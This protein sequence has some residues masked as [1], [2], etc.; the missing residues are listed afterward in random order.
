MAELHSSAISIVLASD[1][2]LAMPMTVAAFS[3]VTNTRSGPIN[4][5]ILDGGIMP[6]S[7][8]KVCRTLVLPHVH[9]HWIR[10]ASARIDEICRKGPNPRYSKAAYFRLLLPEI[11]PSE[12]KKVIYLD[13]DVVVLKD[14]SEL[15]SVEMDG[16]PF[17]AVQEPDGPYMIDCFRTF[18][19]E[20][21]NLDFDKFGIRPEHKYCNSGVMVIDVEKWRREAVM[22]KAFAFLE[23][24]FPRFVDQDALNVVLAG[25]W[26]LLDPKW[27]VTQAFYVA[28]PKCPYG[29]EVIRNVVSDPYIL[30]FTGSPKPW[31]NGAAP[32]LHPGAEFFFHYGRRTAWAWTIRGRRWLGFSRRAAGF[33]RRPV[34]RTRRKLRSIVGPAAPGHGQQEA[35]EKVSS[36]P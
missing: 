21:R 17:L 13:A 30:H 33:L 4:L 18:N 3:A 20:L 26:G 22:E 34:G 2:R 31:T 32:S 11:L 5:F 25:R 6:S 7:R 1:E 9:V 27:N 29:P 19:P 14:L 24:Y 23:T 8:H 36:I 15:W 10:P 16:N 12:I 28:Q 35:V